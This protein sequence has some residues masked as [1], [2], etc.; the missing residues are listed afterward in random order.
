MS[1]NKPRV[2]M[3]LDSLNAGGT[4]TYVFSV[5]KQLLT[6][7]CQVVIAARPGPMRELFLSLG[8]P[9]YTRLSYNPIVMLKQLNRI[10]RKHKINLVHAHQSPSG[11]VSIKAA[12]RNKIPFLFT[13]HGTYYK[14]YHMNRIMKYSHALISVSPPIQQWLEDKNK[15]S[16]LVP[17]GI[18]VEEFHPRPP[19]SL[20][21]E[22]GIP[23]DALVLSYAGRLAWAKADIC[24]DLIQ[25]CRDV[26]TQHF[27][28]LHLVVAGDGKYFNT[29]KNWVDGIHLGVGETFIHMVGYQKRMSEIYSISDCVIGTGRV[30][31]EAMA[32][33]R[34][35]IAVGSKGY[36]GLVQP[37]SY[38]KAKQ[39][40]FGD[41]GANMECTKELLISDIGKV[42]G[43]PV[44]R[45]QWG[46]EGRRFVL[47]N[48]EISSLT[49]E[50]L[51]VYEPL[52]IKRRGRIHQ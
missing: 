2:M 42:L 50:L 15:N 6:Q 16:I 21:Q 26:R 34:P 5:A 35:L 45:E 40:Y 4:E 47:E 51:T 30:A 1:T 19:S 23:K 8:C 33:G 20:R 39:Q 31:L 48:Y 28:N 12:Y 43:S 3:I 29:I 10:I 38:E 13:V 18:D 52:L 32:C 24:K 9:V 17:N 44:E 27:S 36:C 41:H 22:I 49:N 25:A 46:A 14:R 7:G 37:T 11:L